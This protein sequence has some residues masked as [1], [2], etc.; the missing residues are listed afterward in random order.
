VYIITVYGNA[1]VAQ[2]VQ[3]TLPVSTTGAHL[4]TTVQSLTLNGATNQYV[5][6]FNIANSGTVAANGLIVTASQLNGASTSTALPISLG[7][8]SAGASTTVTLVYPTSA[9][10]AGSRGVLTIS[11]SFAG[12]SGGGGSRITLP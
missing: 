10:V 6:V 3:F 7:D 4:I 12:G 1:F 5:A 9:G 2:Q 8:I 11:E